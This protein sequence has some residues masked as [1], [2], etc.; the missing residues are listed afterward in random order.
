MY[1]KNA[2]LKAGFVV[3]LG[4]AALLWLLYV[5]SGQGVWGSWKL[6]HVRFEQG[7]LAP[8]ADDLVLLNGVRVGRVESVH[9]EAAT[10]TDGELTAKDRL[11]LGLEPGQAGTAR[12]IYVHAVLEVEADLALPEGTYAQLNESITGSVDLQLVPGLS[13]AVVSDASTVA[14]PL[15]GVQQ[16]GLS[17]IAGKL[18]DLIADVQKAVGQG[19]GVFSDA[20]ALVREL[21][22]KVQ[23]LDTRGISDDAKAAVATLR[24]ALEG[25]EP[26][27]AR[28]G[29]NVEAATVDLGK[30]AAKGAEAV[31]GFDA[32]VGALLETLKGVAAR[33]DRVLAK[34]EPKIDGFLDSLVRSGQSLEAAAKDLGGLGS[35]AK[36]V[37][38]DAGADL[39]ELIRTLDDAA[40]NILD[41]SEDIRSRPWILL[42]EPEAQEIAFDNVRIAT[43]NYARALAEM[44]RT[45]EQLVKVLA[46]PN[47]ND[48]E[49]RA[50]LR[51][52]VAQFRLSQDKYQRVEQVLFQTLQQA[53]PGGAGAARPPP[54][55]PPSQ[56]PPRR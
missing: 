23:A 2:E 51:Q 19:G 8:K 21:R 25:L 35:D 28:I 40:H 46:S 39:S 36:V 7:S 24:R 29:R 1:V 4:I 6:Y 50:I 34:A 56:P 20:Q 45:T 15:R 12:E 53:A 47:I 16:P 30:M 44:D 43:Q 10:R 48:P 41:A 14:K 49:V 3:I 33:L 5:A 38:R 42:N 54:P 31:E 11:R 37:L 32:D 13:T 18:D 17:D 55:P 9:L 27:L 22:E 52:A 26:A